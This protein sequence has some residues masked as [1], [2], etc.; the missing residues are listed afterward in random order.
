MQYPK[1]SHQPHRRNSLSLP[2]CIIETERLFF[3]PFE[4]ADLPDLAVIYTDVE[5]MQF[6]GKGARTFAEVEAELEQFIADWQK[7]GYGSCAV[8][9]K[10]SGKLIGRSG[11]RASDRSPYPEF[12]YVFRKDGCWGKGF[13]TEAA[14][15]CLEI[16]FS[17]LNLDRLVAFVKPANFA[18]Q[19]ILTKIGM[20]C[21]NANFDYAGAKYL[22]FGRSRA[23]YFSR[24]MM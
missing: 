21:E 6:I 15:A 9:E 11:L 22:Q 7:Y 14:K 17:Q 5:T 12:G 4:R 23:D 18:S 19:R 20:S 2:E 3:R 1:I 24:Q 8:I 10:A 16:G 13:G